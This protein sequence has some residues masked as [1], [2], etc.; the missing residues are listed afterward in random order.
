LE[1]WRFSGLPL[2]SKNAVRVLR[3]AEFRYVYT[4]IYAPYSSMRLLDSYHALI[5]WLAGRGYRADRVTPYDM[6]PHTPHVEALAILM[7]PS[8]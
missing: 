8:P 7:R 2:I 3:L 1:R 5:A 4:R 6:L